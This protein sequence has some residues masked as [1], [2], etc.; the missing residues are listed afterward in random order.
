MKNGADPRCCICTQYVE[1]IEHLI[2]G[3]PTLAPNEYLNRHNTVAQYLHWKICKDYGAP[4]PENW[5]EHQQESVTKPDNVT[6]ELSIT[7]D[8]KV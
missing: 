6:M 1:T 5:Y 4:H 2:F 8:R 3:C 7:T